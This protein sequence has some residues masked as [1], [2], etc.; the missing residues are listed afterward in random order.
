MDGGAI[1][2]GE[3]GPWSFWR[4]DSGVYAVHGMKGEVDLGSG[5]QP[6]IAAGP[7]GVWGVWQGV[8]RINAR[9][10]DDEKAETFSLSTSDRS[11]TNPVVAAS[12]NGLVVAVWEGRPSKGGMGGH[13]GGSK[14][15][16]G[17]SVQAAILARPKK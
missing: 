10:L 2:V 13:A 8:D 17:A 16:G 3:G 4:R 11:G 12:S 1:A 6:W 14:K 7:T 5:R 15:S 9:R